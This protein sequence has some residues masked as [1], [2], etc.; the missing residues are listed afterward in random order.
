[1]RFFTTITPAGKAEYFAI[2]LVLNVILI[3]VAFQVFKLEIN[4]SDRE[5]G[6]ALDKRALMAFVFV[7]YAGLAIINAGRRLKALK[8]GSGMAV[9]AAIPII[10]Q[11]F[12]LSLVVTEDGPSTVTPY[13]GDPYDPNSWVPTSSSA[14]SSDAPAVSFRGEALMLPG[15]ERFDDAA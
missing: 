10:G 11:L 15:E 8:K 12:Q 2:A 9:L 5:I 4:F 14:G 6:Y 1:M 3:V 7:G 13:G